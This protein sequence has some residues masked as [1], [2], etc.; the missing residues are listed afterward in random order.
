MSRNQI[1]VEDFLFFLRDKIIFFWQKNFNGKWSLTIGMDYQKKSSWC[2]SKN[3]IVLSYLI[4]GLKKLGYPY[5]QMSPNCP[6][7]QI[8]GRIVGHI[9]CW[10]I[11]TPTIFPKE[12]WLY[13]LGIV[14][15]LRCW[16]I[17]QKYANDDWYIY[18]YI[19]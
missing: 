9:L 4:P 14:S 12:C 11:C 3:C 13:V 16:R 15:S 10:F 2:S 19:F 5:A 6:S 17:L 7:A 18:N 8:F 1:R